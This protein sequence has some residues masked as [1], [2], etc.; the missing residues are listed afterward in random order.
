M[1]FARGGRQLEADLLDEGKRDATIDSILAAQATQNIMLGQLAMAVLS[2]HLEGDNLTNSILDPKSHLWMGG[3]F[4][5][6]ANKETRSALAAL[7][8]LKGPLP[9]AGGI[10]VSKSVVQ[11]Q[12]PSSTP[13]PEVHNS[14][15]DDGGGA[16][17]PKGG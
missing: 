2:A 15:S 4:L 6:I 14:S 8:R 10:T 12:S 17:K 3:K 13:A 11:I 9:L 7:R 1:Y 5:N 16:R